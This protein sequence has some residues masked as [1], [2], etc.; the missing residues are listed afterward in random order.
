MNKAVE[1]FIDQ[2]LLDFKIEIPRAFGFKG[3]ALPLCPRQLFFDHINPQKHIFPISFNTRYNYH[4][5]QAITAL[6]QE[7][8]ARQSLL[9]GDWQC[10]DKQNCGVSFKSMRLEK[11]LCIRC[12]ET[13]NYIEK[14]V[15]DIETDFTGRVNAVVFC[16]ELQGYLVF[17]L[18]SRNKNVIASSDAPYQGDLYEVSIYAHVLSKKFG[19]PIAGRVL[20]WVGKPKPKPF[21][22]W[23]FHDTGEKLANDMFEVKRKLTKQIEKGDFLNIEGLCSQI[24]DVEMMDCPFGEICLSPDREALIQNQLKEFFKNGSQ[25]I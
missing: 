9:W 24:S 13:A 14:S 8:W 12:G 20:L 25:N 23:Y 11:G 15:S 16:A 21:K 7:T 1:N 18:R 19:L 4:V 6:A 2:T 5:G 22:F 10:S 17:G 3:N